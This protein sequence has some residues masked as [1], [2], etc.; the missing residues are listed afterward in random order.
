MTMFRTV[1]AV[2][3][4]LSLGLSG[5]TTYQPLITNQRK[6]RLEGV[7]LYNR[8]DYDNASGAFR[9]AVRQEPRDYR[10]YLYQGLTYERLNN[11]QQA[12]QSYKSALKVM[13]E[14]PAGRDDIDFRQLTMN[15]LAS[16]VK[17]YDV[18]HLEQNLL[19]TQAADM[20]LSNADR[21]ESCFLLAK[22]DRYRRDADSALL[23]YF[24]ASELNRDDF[25]LQKEAGLY[26]LQLGQGNRAVKSIQRA[27]QL[28]SRDSEVLA[29]M[30]QLR[31]TPPPAIIQGDNGVK[32]IFRTR[33]LPAVDLKIGDAPITL[34]KE[35]PVE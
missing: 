5:C 29:A 25:W 4:L 8:A 26:M 27:N 33:P 34:P 22:V 2:A 12:L 20:K 15:T 21:A 19:A 31:L 7:A 10:S 6:A 18:N 30:N 3:L 14:T 17:K 32:S 23:S 24:K 13:R 11:V 28:S 9:E 16:A 1:L 35:L